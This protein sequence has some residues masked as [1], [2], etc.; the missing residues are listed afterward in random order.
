MLMEVELHIKQIILVQVFDVLE[1]RI[2]QYAFLATF[3][4]KINDHY[5]LLVFIVLGQLFKV[6]AEHQSVFVQSLQ[7]RNKLKLNITDN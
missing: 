3:L 4:D 7:K 1:I 5:A 6:P 2:G